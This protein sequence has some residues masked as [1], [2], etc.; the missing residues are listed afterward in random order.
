MNENNEIPE[1]A[2]NKRRAR[3]RPRARVIPRA[4]KAEHFVPKEVPVRLFCG[5]SLSVLQ[6]MRD[7]SV[8][9]VMTSP[10]YWGQREYNA[11]GIGL[12]ADLGDYVRNVCA[13]MAEIR[14][15]LKPSGSVWLDIADSYRQKSLMGIPSRIELEI[16]R[17]GWILRNVVIWSKVKVGCDSARDRLRNSHEYV[18]HFV[19]SRKYF[20]DIDLIRSKAATTKVV[21]GAVVSASGVSG[22][23]YRRQIECSTALSD[24]EK[25]GALKALGNMLTDVRRGKY[26]DF[27]MIIRGQQRVTHSASAAV[28]GRARELAERGFYFMKYRNGGKPGDV[29]NIMPENRHGRGIHYAAYPEDLCKLPILATCPRDGVVLDPFCGTGTTMVAACRLGRKSVGID[30]SPEYLQ[31]AKERCRR[32]LYAESRAGVSR[33]SR[34][35]LRRPGQGG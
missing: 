13:I 18:F 32:V 31:I 30:I 26:L 4:R 6:K 15:V 14:R 2:A 16:I 7:S 33:G 5:D 23:R 8:D 27:R 22:V 3:M 29:W 12:E 17:Q 20:Y 10:P 34:I 21:N 25:A 19:K 9:C 1:R 28:S 11:G 35:R 24:E